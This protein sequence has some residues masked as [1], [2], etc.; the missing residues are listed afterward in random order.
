M[1]VFIWLGAV[2]QQHPIFF[3]ANLSAAAS[4]SENLR[5]FASPS[6]KNGLRAIGNLTTRDDMMSQADK[7]MFKWVGM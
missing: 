3:S 7:V 5:T 6:D 2:N 1:S 4:K